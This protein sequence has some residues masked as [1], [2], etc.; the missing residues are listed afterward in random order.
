MPL[1]KKVSLWITLNRKLLSY[2]KW[3]R[4]IIQVQENI[5]CYQYA[6]DVVDVIWAKKYVSNKFIMGRYEF[7]RPDNSFNYNGEKKIFG[8]AIYTPIC[9]WKKKINN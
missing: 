9:A 5:I 6:I 2:P 8:I 1:A 4:N 3:K 7:I